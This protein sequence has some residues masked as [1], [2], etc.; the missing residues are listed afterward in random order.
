MKTLAHVVLGVKR[1]LGT[2]LFTAEEI[3]RFAGA[4]DPQP[5][6]MD[7]A[8]AKASQFGGLCASGWHTASI[9]MRL[10]VD[11]MRARGADPA[12]FGPSPGFQDMRWL[13]PV[14]AGDSITY[15]TKPIEK[16]PLA[17][18]PEWGLLASENTGANQH[19]TEVFRFTGLVFVTRA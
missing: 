2:H 16:R 4:F 6:H 9:W 5:F 1:V 12:M 14:F 13:K 10:M 19:G 15:A 18:R 7:E 17:T 8:A 11:D 3:R